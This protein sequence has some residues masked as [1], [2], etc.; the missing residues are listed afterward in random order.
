MRFELRSGDLVVGYTDLE[1][2][3][4]AR[5]IACGRL[6]S[7]VDQANTI[8]QACATDAL[9]IIDTSSGVDLGHCRVERNDRFPQGYVYLEEIAYDFYVQLFP[10]R[11]EDG[12]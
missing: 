4:A 2:G 5:G 7:D 3:D 8:E 9:R 12:M 1:S 6:V 10:E 11:R